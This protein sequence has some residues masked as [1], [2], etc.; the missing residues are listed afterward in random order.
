MIAPIIHKSTGSSQDCRRGCA[1]WSN[2]LWRLPGPNHTVTISCVYDGSYV[3]WRSEEHTS[4]LQSQSNL[5]C[6]LLLEKKTRQCNSSRRALMMDPARQLKIH[7]G[8][9]E[10]ALEYATAPYYVRS[11]G[12]DRE[13]RRTRVVT[14]AFDI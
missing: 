5:V 1:E 12:H 6:R 2:S 10:P 9:A 14:P 3:G 13:I 11:G 7:V 8:R 4:E